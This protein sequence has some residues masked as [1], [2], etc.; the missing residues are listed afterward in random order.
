MSFFHHS[1]CYINN[2]KCRCYSS[3]LVFN[4]SCPAPRSRQLT[5]V[6]RN[7]KPRYAN[8]A[9]VPLRNTRNIKAFVYVLMC[10]FCETDPTNMASVLLLFIL[11][12]IV[13][14]CVFLFFRGVKQK[15]LSSVGDN[16]QVSLTALYTV[17]F[18]SL[19]QQ[20]RTSVTITHPNSHLQQVRCYLFTTY[21][22]N[23][24]E[25]LL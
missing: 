11:F 8:F 20:F 10:Y 16:W 21:P 22:Q 13:F 5:T 9:D 24:T 23:C 25:L 17:I 14:F 2:F 6:Q 3:W 4:F 15:S 7:S 12:G 19:K 18:E 1:Y